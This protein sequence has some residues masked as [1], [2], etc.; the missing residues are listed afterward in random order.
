[1]AGDG[2]H[3]EWISRRP[4]NLFD[5]TRF[6]KNTQSDQIT[7]T[8]RPYRAD[9]YILISAGPDGE[10]GTADDICNFDWKYKQ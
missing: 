2:W 1:M 10:Y 7:T 9:Q 5:P 3:V 8:R 6:Y 4:T